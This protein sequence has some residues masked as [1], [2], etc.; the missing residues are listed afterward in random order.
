M[1]AKLR[2][3][4]LASTSGSDLPA[5]F[6]M[7]REH[8]EFVF[9]LTNKA[10]CG[11]REKARQFG[12]SDIFLDPK[13]LTREAYDTQILELL[14]KEQIDLVLLIGWM[15]LLSPELVQAYFG[16]MLNVH[17]SLLPAFAGGMDLDVHAEV[18]A[19]GVKETGATVHFVT[20]EADAGPILLQE[21]CS[22]MP[23]DTP[24]TLK[25]KVQKIEQGLLQKAL[26]LFHL[27]KIEL[28]GN[29]V[30]ILP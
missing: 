30:K 6:S 25:A 16:R 13:G 20:E 21:S 12:V 28:R 22:I 23:E 14:E 15:R 4:V 7:D 27:E 19:S 3:A 18:L 2:I 5:V 29:S 1:K 17:P 9:L 10:D 8:Y 11:A 24:E 26:E